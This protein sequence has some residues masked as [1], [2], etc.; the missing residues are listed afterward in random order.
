[1]GPVTDA[2]PPICETQDESNA[3]DPTTSEEQRLAALQLLPWYHRP[4]IKWLLPF[5]F[6]VA[7]ALGNGMG[8]H[9]QMLIKIVC[10]AYYW[11][12]NEAYDDEEDCKASVVQAL[13]A[14]LL[15]RL[16]S[17]RAIAGKLIRDAV[18]STITFI[19]MHSH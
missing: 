15:S 5:V 16:M 12:S 11:G 18:F 6:L 13:G 17:I 14:V 8:P 19:R 10:K 4:S 7:T 2:E 1:M 3:Q 9:D